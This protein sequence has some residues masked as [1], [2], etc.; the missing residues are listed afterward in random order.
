ME[1]TREIRASAIALRSFAIRREQEVQGEVS[2]GGRTARPLRAAVAW[3][4]PEAEELRIVAE[5]LVPWDN[6]RLRTD[7]DGETLLVV[8]GQAAGAFN[9][10][11]RYQDL[12]LPAG[13][14]RLELRVA[15][16]GLMG[17]RFSDPAVRRIAFQ[18]IDHTVEAIAY[19]LEVL[20]DFAH[21]PG[22]P[23][24]AADYAKERLILAL[25][26]L[27]ALP[28]DLGAWRAYLFG[29]RHDAEEEALRLALL[30]GRGEAP[31]L[32]ALAWDELLPA[33]RET[34][35]RLRQ[36]FRDLRGRFPSGAGRLL[37]LGHAH[38]D[39]A[40]LWP[41]AVSR[42][43]AVRTFASQT[44]LLERV[45]QWRFGASSPELWTW[46]EEDAPQLHARAARLVAKDRI[47]PLGAFW[48]E[49]DCQLP[50]AESILRQLLYGMRYFAGR[51]GSLP[52]IAFLPDTFGFAAGLPTL[53]AAAGVRLFCTTKLNWNDTTRF[54]YVDFTWV[55]PDGASVQGHI[56]GHAQDGYNAPASLRDLRR[57]WERYEQLGGRRTLLYTFGHGD[58]GGGP[59]P[60]MVEQ[61]ARYRELPF[62]PELSW[63]AAGTLVAQDSHMPLYRGPLY[64][65][66]HRGTYTTQS[67]AKYL[68]RRAEECLT[69]AEALETWARHGGN[70]APAEAWRLLLRGQFHDILPG[71]SIGP[72]YAD[73]REE[74]ES[75]LAQA[76]RM[77]QQ[78]L[79]ALLPENGGAPCLAVQN[80]AG[81][82]APAQIV[83]I[84][85]PLAPVGA[86]GLAGTV[87]R[88]ADGGY[89]IAIPELPPFGVAALPLVPVAAP[90][91]VPPRRCE[92]VRLR[93]EELELEVGP[94]GLRSLLFRG[95]ELLAGPA[96]VVAFRQHPDAFDA[97]EISHPARR[98]DVPLRHGD[99]V[100]IEDGELRAL[101]E[102][103]HATAEG[104]EVLERIILD[105][106]QGQVEL[107]ITAALRERHLVLRYRI[108][109]ALRAHH[110]T[111][112]ALYGVETHP[113]IP[114]GP[115]DAAAFEWPAHRF[116]D[117]SEASR[118][119]A[120]L[121]DSRYGHAAEGSELH[122]TLATSPLFPDPAADEHPAPARVALRPHAG[123]WHEARVLEAA[124]AFSAGTVLELRLAGPQPPI[125]PVEGLPHG[126]RLLGLKPAED[127]SGDVIAHLAE[128]IGDSGQADV[129]F[130]WPARV[131]QRVH[132][133]RETPEESGAPLP[134][135]AA[136]GAFAVRYRPWEL[137]CLRITGA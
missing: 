134:R 14:H 131:A 109:T 6:P 123:G 27:R 56:F 83:R 135:D 61:L 136:S 10:F 130:G 121:N 104:S 108:P 18:E 30:D 99:P 42:D 112:E 16:T 40:W 19:D 2:V 96:G 74:L 36:V 60:E 78:G 117:I 85:E 92:S 86:S 88:S 77:A 93:G 94:E 90:S 97:W 67:W 101:V 9:A 115:A 80:R 47:E 15:R 41:M 38:I 37:L 5:G 51:F 120:V 7:L 79:G 84:G 44:A 29:G 24:V 132:P 65:E 106:V 73:L 43:K 4:D 23:P 49:S 137:I 82:T 57:A 26:P 100:L 110:V 122:V 126:M 102:I 91:P 21:D 34:G 59:T 133:V 114:R 95:R 32:R 69:S 107:E 31:G 35:A 116:V 68:G 66:Y 105:R 129:R 48:V 118:G 33:V 11:H 58:G 22:T 127:G 63:D 52:E 89:L 39:L 13:P 45:P 50:S 113:T 103:R 72:V 76:G 81:L 46:L 1:L 54:P 55:G 75:V 53:L 17:V 71:S 64:L 111:A 8:D 3:P 98:S 124:A 87:Q 62:L 70:A 20:G 128:S 125:G 12:Y 25:A 28:P 119:L